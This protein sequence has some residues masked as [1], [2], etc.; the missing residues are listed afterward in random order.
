M[1]DEANPSKQDLHLV[2][3][4]AESVAVKK[5][6]SSLNLEAQ[7]ALPNQTATVIKTKK[8]PENVNIRDSQVNFDLD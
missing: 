2:G 8:E 6:Q 7:A 4:V 1:L 5:M 3:H